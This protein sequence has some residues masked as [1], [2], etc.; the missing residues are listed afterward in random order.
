M[1]YGYGNDGTISCNVRTRRRR[2]MSLDVVI[3]LYYITFQIDAKK[4]TTQISSMLVS[5]GFR[6]VVE[7]RARLRHNGIQEEILKASNMQETIY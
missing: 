2:R 6:R 4:T 3:L 1:D 7:T 5:K